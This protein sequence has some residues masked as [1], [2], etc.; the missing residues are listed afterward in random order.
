VDRHSALRCLNEHLARRAN[1]EDQCTGRFW[2]G[3]FKSQALLD[4]AGLL[5]AMAYVD[6]NPI[7]AGIATTPEESEFTSIYARIEA[8]RSGQ[9]PQTVPLL[10]FHAPGSGRRKSRSLKHSE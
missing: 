4:E 8:L 10:S 1:G 9:D 6:L 5:T 3:R 7:R 2:E